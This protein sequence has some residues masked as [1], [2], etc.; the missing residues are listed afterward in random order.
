MSER[1][2]PGQARVKQWLMDNYRQRHGESLPDIDLDADIIEARILDSL[3]LMNFICILEEVTEAEIPVET[4]DVE[5]MR[6][7]RRIFS[8]YLASE[9]QPA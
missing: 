6:T 2:S 3:S 7:L 4:V 9:T 8:T 1:L 5:N